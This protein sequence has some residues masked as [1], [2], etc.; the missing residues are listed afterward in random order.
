MSRPSVI[1]SAGNSKLLPQ[2][3]VAEFRLPRLGAG[4]LAAP[5]G[6]NSATKDPTQAASQDDGDAHSGERV[7]VGQGLPL[8][9]GSEIAE[10]DHA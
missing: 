6:A 3:G 10:A 7:A 5:E 9:K 2:I 4:R 1:S 8:D